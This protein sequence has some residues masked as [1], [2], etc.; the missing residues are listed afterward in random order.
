MPEK[1]PTITVIMPVY[2]AERYLRESISSILEQTFYD[3][4]FL[5]FNDGSTDKSLAVIQS[6]SDSRIKVLD[7]GQNHGLVYQLNQGL[8]L[9]R[10]KYL[11]RMDAD[12]ISDLFRFEKQVKFMD[13][14]PEIGLCGTWMDTIGPNGYVLQFPDNDHDIRLASIA[15]SCFG[16]PSVMI[17]SS[18]LRENNLWYQESLLPAEDYHFWLEIGA[19]TKLANIPEFLVH[20]RLHDGQISKQKREAQRKKAQLARDSQIE[21]LLERTLSKDEKIWNALI[22]DP[23]DREL[24][25]DMVLKLQ[26]WNQHLLKAN[27]IRD[28]YDQSKFIDLL[29][30]KLY[31][32]VRNYYIQK[33]VESN[34]Y[35]VKLLIE[36]IS[37]KP[38]AFKYLGKK[39]SFK[40][41]FKC[42]SLKYF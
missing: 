40:F 6:F 18:V 28:L 36:F 21:A 24:T 35:G 27:Q 22:F 11:A 17:R 2:N 4:E 42:L 38:F 30:K 10:G 39:G 14:N 15:D 8:Q 12:D 32:V 37:S 25:F 3:F 26:N 13:A 20:Y 19:Y 34:Q 1:E 9:A 29:S 23:I 33:F 16:H 31:E 5:I 41:L 7:D